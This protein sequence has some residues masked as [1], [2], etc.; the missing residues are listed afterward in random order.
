MLLCGAPYLPCLFTWQAC[1]EVLP[2]E[3]DGQEAED[4]QN[5]G[6]KH[7]IPGHRQGDQGALQV[8]KHSLSGLGNALL[9]SQQGFNAGSCCWIVSMN[10]DFVEASE[11]VSR[12]DVTGFCAIEML[13]VRQIIYARVLAQ[14]LWSARAGWP[15]TLQQA[16]T[17][18]GHLPPSNRWHS[19]GYFFS[20]LFV[21]LA[22]VFLLLGTPGWEEH[23]ELL[24]TAGV[25]GISSGWLLP[26]S[27]LHT[28]CCSS[29]L[30]CREH[31]NL[32]LPLPH[33]GAYRMCLMLC[34][35]VAAGTWDIQLVRAPQALPE[36]SVGNSGSQPAF[37]YVLAALFSSYPQPSC[38][39][40]DTLSLVVYPREELQLC[41]V[42]LMSSAAARVRI[43]GVG[44]DHALCCAAGLLDRKS[45]V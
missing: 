21:R 22:A 25:R 37:C 29:F 40:K 41:K 10:F 4:F 14:V 31:I 9:R 35:P 26:P 45:V 42:Q 8:G 19:L 44:P 18:D 43:R 30:A 23:W 36:Q 38:A 12:N 13:S 24:Q 16:S 34:I 15:I 20:L 7:P 2:K 17:E 27:A 28:Q 1:C 39:Y 11:L 5:P 6:P 32:A 3:A 33:R